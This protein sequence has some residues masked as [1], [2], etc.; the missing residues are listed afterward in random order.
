MP[1]V[2]I[3]DDDIGIRTHLAA[4]VRE[5]GHEVEVARDSLEALA[6]TAAGGFDVVI[7]DVRMAG[8]D[9][10]ALLREIRGRHPDTGV[11]LMTAYA[12]VPDAVE[13]MRRGA[14]DYLVKP[15][16]LEQAGFVLSRLLEVQALRRIDAGPP[17]PSAAKAPG[18][19]RELERA[20]VERVLA[21]AATLEEAAARLGINTTTLWRMRKRWGLE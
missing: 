5:L 21:E 20:H 11:I 4:Y 10:L 7:S 6:A 12:T 8:M 15:F 13:A 14:Y 16:S 9:G 3:V 18:S 19:L 17:A 2:L 1:R